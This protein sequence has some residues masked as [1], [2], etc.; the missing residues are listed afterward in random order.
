MDLVLPT[1]IRLCRKGLPETNAL[2]YYKKLV[3]YGRKKFHNIQVQ[4]QKRW[5]EHELE[6]VDQ[7]HFT[8]LIL[9]KI[10]HL[11]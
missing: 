2:A 11:T 7:L 1:I 4:E 8:S 5:L 3:N 10:T 6:E 9:S